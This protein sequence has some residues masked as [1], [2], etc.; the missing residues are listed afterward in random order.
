MNIKGIISDLTTE[1]MIRTFSDTGSI[2][3]NQQVVA[4]SID[5][6]AQAIEYCILTD[7]DL[8]ESLLPAISQE[9]EINIA[10]C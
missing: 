1:L 2:K 10:Y 7:L 6:I 5:S 9:E 3:S 4:Q 8:M